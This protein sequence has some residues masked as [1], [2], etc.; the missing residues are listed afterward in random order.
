MSKIKIVFALVF[1]FSSLSLADNADKK[2]DQGDKKKET[3]VQVDV[4]QFG[5]PGLY[6]HKVGKSGRLIDVPPAYYSLDFASW[7]DYLILSSQNDKK[8]ENG[9]DKNK[10]PET[11]VDPRKYPGLFGHAPGRKGR[12]IDL[13]PSY[14]S[15]GFNTDV[16]LLDFLKRF[17]SDVDLL[18]FLKRFQGTAP[19]ISLVPTTLTPD[20]ALLAAMPDPYNNPWVSQSKVYEVKGVE[21]TGILQKLASAWASMTPKQKELSVGSCVVIGV[22]VV[23][24]LAGG[25]VLIA[26]TATG[27][28]VM[29]VSSQDAS[30]ETFDS[31]VFFVGP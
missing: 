9:T 12:V 4:R 6:G 26:A 24:Y 2:Q 28:L 5:I 25:P 8:T 19:D 27:V 11:Q 7:R 23:V 22:G 31:Q 18:D 20:E 15:L 14:F 30:A 13:P 21:N 29:A 17:E 16:D 1:L 10:A 3:Q